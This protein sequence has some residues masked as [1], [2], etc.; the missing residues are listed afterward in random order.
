[1]WRIAQPTR[2]RMVDGRDYVAVV[3]DLVAAGAELKQ[4]FAEVA[5]GPL[6]DWLDRETSPD[7]E[8]STMP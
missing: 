5:H 1:M 8:Q 2:R 6:A 4:R 7:R 3:E